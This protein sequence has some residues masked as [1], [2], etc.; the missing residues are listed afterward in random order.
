[1]YSSDIIDY[2]ATF[3]DGKIFMI[4]LKDVEGQTVTTLRVS[5][6]YKNKYKSIMASSYEI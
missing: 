2:F 4:P 1:L 5:E 3:V 6:K